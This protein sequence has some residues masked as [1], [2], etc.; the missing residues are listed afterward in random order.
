MVAVLPAEAWALAGNPLPG[1][2]RRE[3]PIARRPW[4]ARPRL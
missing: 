3:T 4:P 1:Y 2:A